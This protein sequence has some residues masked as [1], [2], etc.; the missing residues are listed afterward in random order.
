MHRAWGWN[1]VHILVFKVFLAPSHRGVALAAPRFFI[2]WSRVRCSTQLAL[3]MRFYNPKSSLKEKLLT[4]S[5]FKSSAYNPVLSEIYQ[6]CKPGF[7]AIIGATFPDITNEDI[8]E[9]YD[10]A[11]MALNDNVETGKLTELTCSLQT[12][13]NHI[14][15]NKV[16]DSLRK[17]KISTVSYSDSENDWYSKAQEV[18]ESCDEEDEKLLIVLKI[19][20]AMTEPCKTILFYFY[21]L[22]YSMKLIAEK[23]G[24]KDSD[25][26]KTSKNR[27]MKKLK[28][29]TELQLRNQGLN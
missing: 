1:S 6:E 16:I 23:M 4:A 15:K 12:Y 10:D 18:V 3:D 21:H 7:F 26:A 24:L 2:V 5:Q 11:I 14:G 29:T 19:V 27:C 25:S 28:D 9:A 13:I 20:E 22:E 17:K 8:E